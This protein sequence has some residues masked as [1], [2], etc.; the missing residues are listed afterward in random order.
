VGG[1]VV[2]I[3]SV[4]VTVLAASIN[5]IG[6]NDKEYDTLNSSWLIFSLVYAPLMIAISK[7]YIRI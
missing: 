6:V 2:L 4:A 1:I 3:T 5:Y 7:Y